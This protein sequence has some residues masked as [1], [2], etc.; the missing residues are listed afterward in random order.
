MMLPM[1][2]KTRF[3]SVSEPAELI[4]KHK[5]VASAKNFYPSPPH[6]RSCRSY[7]SYVAILSF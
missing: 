7:L 2:G 5:I 6:M 4:P 3:L 1:P